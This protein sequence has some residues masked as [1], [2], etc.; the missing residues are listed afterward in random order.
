MPHFPPHL[1]HAITCLSPTTPQV[2]VDLVFSDSQ[3]LGL[4]CLL[5]KAPD[6][7]FQSS[8][9]GWLGLL[10]LTAPE[11]HCPLGGRWAAELHLN[12]K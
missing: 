11:P 10:E 3:A 2:Q 9:W 5:E 6:L 12:S 4:R 8:G 7:P 1:S